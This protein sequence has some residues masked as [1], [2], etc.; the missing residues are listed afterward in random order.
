MAKKTMPQISQK[1]FN[2]LARSVKDTN[3]RVK[4]ME[5]ALM[6]DKDLEV[7]GMA[8]K[9]AA[10]GKYIAKDKRF[11]YLATGAIAGGN[12][13]FWAWIKSHLGI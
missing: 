8:E 10:H 3:D 4:R 9:V 7:V 1:S 11:K 2:T 5:T 6:G 13:G 12:I